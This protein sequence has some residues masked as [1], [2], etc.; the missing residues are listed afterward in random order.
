MCLVSKYGKI[1]EEIVVSYVPDFTTHFY[2]CQNANVV[3][4]FTHKNIACNNMGVI[5]PQNL[6]YGHGINIFLGRKGDL[7]VTFAPPH[8][9]LYSYLGKRT[10]K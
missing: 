1:L 10:A 6:Y 3:F 9:F 4:C 5:I 2:S 7:R 8:A